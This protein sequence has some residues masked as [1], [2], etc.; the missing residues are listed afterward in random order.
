MT[1]VADARRHRASTAVLAACDTATTT[2]ELLTRVGD[3]AR[4]GLDAF[5][6]FLCTTDPVTMVLNAEAVVTELPDDMRA[7]WM[8]NEFLVDDVN[9]FGDLHR[10][11][12]LAAS[13]A[14]TVERDGRASARATEVNAVFGFGPELR[15]VFS[16]GDACW[17]AAN[18]LRRTGE[19]EFTA[20]DR[21][22]LASICT[23][24]AEALRRI[25]L[26]RTLLGPEVASPGLI[27]LDPAGRVV[28]QSETA[29]ELVDDL[30][31]TAI[32]AGPDETLP[33]QAISVVSA[34]R[35]HAMNVATT[36]DPVTRVQG[37][38][39]HWL[40]LR[41]TH[42]L[43]EDG[44]LAHLLLTI[45]PANPDDI[46]AMIAVAY[47]LTP[48]E[49]DVFAELRLGGSME[50]TAARMFI[51]V[52]TLRT[53]VRSLFAKTGCSSRGELIS[54]LFIHREVAESA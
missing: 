31:I 43:T 13:L 35:G 38:S 30:F 22:W 4:G 52:H 10:S 34:A 45:E 33:C 12:T 7:P 54:R 47:G 17:A 19:A 49:K 42:A 24:V 9:K 21:D 11:G 23:P 48:R 44:E 1:R 50:E 8:Q 28:S 18:F 26:H 53:H 29:Q 32:Y 40:S 3:A 16:Q 46:M 20:D 39:G 27:V 6:S 36:L 2:R 37:R 51:S 15:A 5:G 41:G 14:E 25:V